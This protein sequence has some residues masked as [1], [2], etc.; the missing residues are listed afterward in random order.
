MEDLNRDEL[1]ELLSR[2]YGYGAVDFHRQI[3]DDMDEDGIDTEDLNEE[4]N[5]LMDKFYADIISPIVKHYQNTGVI[6]EIEIKGK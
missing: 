6:P 3:M 1:A 4:M 5:S 2:V